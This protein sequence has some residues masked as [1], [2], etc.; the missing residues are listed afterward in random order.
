MK[1]PLEGLGHPLPPDGS[2]IDKTKSP[3][4]CGEAKIGN[5]CP[6]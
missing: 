1:L 6:S 3:P 2:H 5:L 4:S